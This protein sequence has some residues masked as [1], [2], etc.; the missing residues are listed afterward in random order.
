[1]QQTT[2]EWAFILVIGLH[3]QYKKTPETLWKR[4]MYFYLINAI[5]FL[6]PGKYRIYFFFTPSIMCVYLHFMFYLGLL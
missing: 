2:F 1:M 5:A 6:P 3:K 4:N